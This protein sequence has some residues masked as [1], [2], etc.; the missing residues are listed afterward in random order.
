MRMARRSPAPTASSVP[1]MSIEDAFGELALRRSHALTL[2]REWLSLAYETASRRFSVGC[3]KRRP[4]ELAADPRL[5]GHGG[6]RSGH[7]APCCLVQPCRSILSSERG[8][9]AVMTVCY[10]MYML[11]EKRTLGVEDI[12]GPF[13]GL[14]AERL[15]AST[16]TFGWRAAA[17]CKPPNVARPSART[18]AYRRRSAGYEASSQS[19][20]AG[21]RPR[22]SCTSSAPPARCRR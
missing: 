11:S 15:E 9:R 13:S 14:A 2:L 6:R 7:S 21:M 1:T 10:R 22:A 17:R 18:C 19:S 20:P 12:Q 3:S 16:M 4:R 5:R 8:R